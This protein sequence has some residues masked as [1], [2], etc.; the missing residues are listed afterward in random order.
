[1]AKQTRQPIN[2]VLTSHDAIVAIRVM[3]E[4][5]TIQLNGA[6]DGFEVIAA[7]H[8]FIEKI[9]DVG[10]MRDVII[11]HYVRNGYTPTTLARKVH[12]KITPSTV[13]RAL[14]G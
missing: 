13:S 6:T 4:A 2:D 9:N 12:S 8:P 10:L 1:M 5:L 14:S 3:V 7:I 11:R